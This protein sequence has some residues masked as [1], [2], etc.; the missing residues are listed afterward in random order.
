[1]FCFVLFLAV[2]LDDAVFQMVYRLFGFKERACFVLS[3]LNFHIFLFPA[4]FL[5]F[6]FDPFKK[7]F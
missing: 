6:L 2:S 1:M 7:S 4:I 3:S 5:S